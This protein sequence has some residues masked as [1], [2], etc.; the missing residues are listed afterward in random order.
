VLAE[1]LDLPH[2]EL[3]PNQHFFVWTDE[4]LSEGQLERVS[5]WQAQ[6]FAITFLTDAGTA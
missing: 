2:P 6:G 3:F 4:P 5:H 1:P